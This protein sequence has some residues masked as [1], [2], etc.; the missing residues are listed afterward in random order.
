MV[1]QIKF[2]N[3]I[4]SIKFLSST[5]NVLI[6]FLAMYNSQVKKQYIFLN[7]KCETQILF[8]YTRKAKM[9][10]MSLGKLHCKHEDH[11]PRI[12]FFARKCTKPRVCMKQKVKHIK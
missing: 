3:L 7:L 8:L 4:P 6:L 11:T 2:Y 1:T 5:Q 12:V 10:C 9:F